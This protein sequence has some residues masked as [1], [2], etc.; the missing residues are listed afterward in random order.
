MWCK[1]AERLGAY[2]NF[3]H[4]LDRFVHLGYERNGAWNIP[5]SPMEC[6]QMWSS[7]R[8]QSRANAADV[9]GQKTNLFAIITRQIGGTPQIGGEIDKGSR[10]GDHCSHLL[11]IMR[12]IGRPLLES[13]QHGL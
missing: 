4:E 2:K 12:P 1:N 13:P 9:L 8:Q 5:L 10:K 11:C 3:L 6:I 7:F